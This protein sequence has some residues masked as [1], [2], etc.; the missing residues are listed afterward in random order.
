MEGGFDIIYDKKN[1]NAFIESKEGEY[2]QFQ[3]HEYSN[4]IT[5]TVDDTG[6]RQIAKDAEELFGPPN[7]DQVSI[8]G[9]HGKD[10]RGVMPTDQALEVLVGYAGDVNFASIDIGTYS[11]LWASPRLP[12]ALFATEAG[13]GELSIVCEK[14]CGNAVESAMRTSATPKIGRHAVAILSRVFNR[15]S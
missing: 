11:V 2:V 9:L 1:G 7:A 12:N 8:L 13:Y 5:W 4:T 15:P 14:D 10:T 3:P 6:F